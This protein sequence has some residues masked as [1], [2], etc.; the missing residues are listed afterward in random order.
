VSSTSQTESDTGLAL[1]TPLKLLLCAAGAG[2][3]MYPEV[4]RPVRGVALGDGVVDVAVGLQILALGVFVATTERRPDRSGTAREGFALIGAVA[5]PNLVLLS[6]FP[7]ELEPLGVLLSCAGLAG[8]VA[9][10]HRGSLT[11]RG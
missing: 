3:V 6:Q 10:E 4:L 11:G 2:V 9:Y 1:P 5:A 7:T 8:L